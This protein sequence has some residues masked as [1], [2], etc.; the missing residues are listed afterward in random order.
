MSRFSYH[1]L[2]LVVISAFFLGKYLL[3]DVIGVPYY[4]EGG[5]PIFKIHIYS[6][7]LFLSSLYVVF[8]MGAR[9]ALEVLLVHGNSIIWYFFAVLYVAVSGFLANGAG[10]MAYVID[11][12]LAPVFVLF[13]AFHLTELQLQNILKLL[14]ACLVINSSLALLEFIL[15]SNLIPRLAHVWYFRPW[16]FLSHPLNNSL[17]TSSLMFLVVC[18]FSTPKKAISIM[19][20]VAALLAFGGRVATVLV[21]LMLAYFF[22]KEA[23]CFLFCKKVFK[24]ND[25]IFMHY[26]VTFAL[27]FFV[28]AMEVGLGER[29]FNGFEIDGSAQTRLDVYLLFY[30]I[31]FSELLWGVEPQF[32]LSVKDVVG[33]ATIENAW[34]GWLFQFGLIATI[35][36][37]LT[38]FNLLLSLTKGMKYLKATAVLF[39][40]ICSANNS[41]ST[42]TPALMFY[43][44]ALYSSSVFF[45]KKRLMGSNS[46][47]YNGLP[48]QV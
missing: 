1:S 47:L 19:F 45:E 5:S 42:K 39:V 4:H 32:Y 20:F 25:V 28:I 35:P 38:L 30:T 6:Y 21:V 31:S 29:V 46:Y 37:I 11:T 40:I 43:V 12:L 41:L 36:L 27:V 23:F 18:S 17:I 8:K 44:L 15:H 33:V 24:R 48:R 14:F 13:L 16:A 9:K 34:L 3:N 10:G 7:I 22:I 2:Y 26:Y